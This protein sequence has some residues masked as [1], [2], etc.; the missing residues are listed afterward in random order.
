ME[1]L[2]LSCS[3]EPML[4]VSY[5]QEEEEE[6]I[7]PI[8]LIYSFFLFARERGSFPLSI[9]SFPSFISPVFHPSFLIFS[10]IICLIKHSRLKDIMKE[11]H[12]QHFQNRPTSQTRKMH[13]LSVMLYLYFKCIYAFQVQ[14]KKHFLCNTIIFSFM[15]PLCIIITYYFMDLVRTSYVFFHHLY[16]LCSGMNFPE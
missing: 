3:V 9:L 7:F 5:H 1:K 14:G 8:S 13:I 11:M 15:H 10:N 16:T 2:Y 12:S 4:Y 6:I